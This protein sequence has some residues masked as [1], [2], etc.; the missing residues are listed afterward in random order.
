MENQ[1]GFT[2]IHQLIYTD[3][4][5]IFLHGGPGGRTSSS[6]TI[7]FD[8]AVYRIVLLDQ[9]GAG[10]SLPPAELR[11]NTTWHLVADIE[12]LREHLGIDKWHMVFG[13]SWGST[14]ALCYAQAHPQ[15]VGSLVLRGIFTMRRCEL[16]WS[17]R[18][19]A[20]LFP[21]LVQEFIN[22]IP[23]DDRADPY[24]AYHRLLMAEISA[25]DEEARLKRMDAARA[26]DAYALA[27][28]C[29]Q[30]NT[31]KLNDQLEDEASFLA[32]ARLEYQY[33][34]NAAWLEEGQLLRKEN[35][36]KMRH[37]PSEFSFFMISLTQS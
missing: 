5:V 10:K 23:E 26:W 12:S 37:I 7:Y 24:V 11:D 36:D 16:E 29:L 8:P 34:V 15:R 25:D 32:H 21:D 31:D 4:T 9:R 1:V 28:G 17:R 27:T 18:P 19:A 30:P 22:Y 6:N 20:Q 3:K 35:L 33:F 13:G 2:S 14:L